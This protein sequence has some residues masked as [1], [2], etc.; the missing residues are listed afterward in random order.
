MAATTG[1]TSPAT[2]RGARGPPRSFGTAP[3]PR[4]RTTAGEVTNAKVP[5]TTSTAPMATAAAGAA[6]C[7]TP[8]TTNGPD[9]NSSSSATPSRLYARRNSPRSAASSLHTVRIV[10]PSGGVQAPATTATAPSTGPDTPGR[11]LATA[12]TPRST[13][14]S[15]AI[16]GSAR[17]GPYR[18]TSAARTG[19]RKT[20][21]APNRAMTV[22]ATAY[23]P[24]ARV[25][26]S[27]T[28][29]GTMP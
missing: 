24:V 18:S 16:G 27:S 21:V 9:T 23:D 25:T 26:A 11:Q 2:T 3:C 6:N 28:A 12:S 22:P 19:D 15:E 1:G 8:P 14:Y 13:A 29:T 4:I 5:A 10:G 20:L 17:R 7:T